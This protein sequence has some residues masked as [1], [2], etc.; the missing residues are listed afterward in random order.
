[1]RVAALAIACSDFDLEF[2]RSQADAAYA[3]LEQRPDF[4]G[5]RQTVSDIDETTAA[6]A[7]IADHSPDKLVVIQSTF[8]DSSMVAEIAAG[9]GADLVLWALPEERTGGRLRLN[10]FGGINL[11]AHALGR[12][13][14]DYDYLYASPDGGAAAL[15]TEVI[16]RGREH[17]GVPR[18]IVAETTSGARAAARDVADYLDGLT[19]GL[20]GDAP[21]GFDSSYHA[22][23]VL[24]QL[25]GVNVERRELAEMFELG[26][27]A[28]RAPIAI[29][30]QR[31]EQALGDLSHLDQEGLEAS[32]RIYHGLRSLIEKHRWSGVATRCWPECFTEMGGAACAPQAMLNEDSTPGFCEADVYGA[33]TGLILQQLAQEPAWLADLVDIR[34]EDNTGIF[35]HCG[36]APLTMADQRQQVGA[37]IHSNH[38][39]PLLHEFALKPGRV[40]IAR[41]SQARG[42]H[43]MVLGGGEMVRAPLA[44]SGTAGTLR[45]D[46]DAVHVFDTIMQEG[47]EHH[48]GIVYGEYEEELVALADAWDIPVVTLG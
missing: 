27:Q 18:E 37:T 17:R 30:R 9:T 45:F 19:I 46:R 25:T 20:I 26:R 12:R 42:E 39:K 44:F 28:E 38:H 1:M 41:L 5:P 15:L 48:Y 16:S 24:A 14:R 40:T 29:A 36:L 3:L 21:T 34:P 13:G 11:A 10:S 22:P 33:V 6:L 35:W 7:V 8:S 4:V 47:L 31:A 43:K 2:A 23:D 32:F